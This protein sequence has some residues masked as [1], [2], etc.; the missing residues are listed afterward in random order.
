MF[1]IALTFILSSCKDDFF[2]KPI[3][4]TTTIDS[5]FS[6]SLK[7]QAAIASAYASVT[8]QGLTT[9]WDGSNYAGLNQG[10][11]DNHSGCLL[12]S[13][14]WDDG[15]QIAV[16]SGMT[17]NNGSTNDNNA[18]S[19][20][21][22]AYNFTAI[23]QCYQVFQNIDNVSDMT[24]SDKEIVKAEMKTLIAYRYTQMFTIYGGV[25]IVE[26][27]YSATDIITGER[28]NLTVTLDFIKKL[29]DEAAAVLPHTWEAKWNGR[30]TKCVALAI[31]AKALLFAARPLFNSSSPYLDLGSDNDLICFNNV[32]PQ[33]W[34]D[35]K[36]ANLDVLA[37]A[38]TA[39]IQ[40]INTGNP[41]DDYGNATSTPGNKELIWVFKKQYD[42]YGD[43]FSTSYLINPKSNFASYLMRLSYFYLKQYKTASGLDQVWAASGNYPYSDYQTKMNA[44]EPRFK[45]S[46]YAFGIDSW[47]NPNDNSWKSNNLFGDL[48]NNAIVASTKFYYKAGTRTWFE[49]PLF[50]LAANYLAL[51]ESYNES[52]DATNALTYLNVIRV[53]A[54]LPAETETDK[55]KLR[56][57]IIREWAVEMFLEQVWLQSEKHWKLANIGTEIIGGDIK[58]FKQNYKAATG[59]ASD[60]TSYDVVVAYKGYWNDRQFLNP[61]PQNEI[62]KGSIIQNPGY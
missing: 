59:L 46:F 11:I 5:V 25:P 15:Y 19:D 56:A 57:I 53:R 26:K 13:F 58:T 30:A 9:G 37:E 61:F 24:T 42:S 2:Q 38:A 49:L 12:T 31:K 47:G 32:D 60:F 21:S 10:T 33:R 4:A 1:V 41:L 6:T 22:Y 48:Y 20:D 28:A 17:A 52:G 16:N 55:I 7:A 45:A 39:G 34:I 44:M 54:G 14:S 18:R 36:D 62:N 43:A 23:R 51:A 50:R 27:A 29:C 8:H 40:V 35:A 3:G